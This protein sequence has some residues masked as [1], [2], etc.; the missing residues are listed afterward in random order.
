MGGTPNDSIERRIQTDEVEVVFMTDEKR[1][2]K[3]SKPFTNSES[4]NTE[5]K[6]E[7][8]KEVSKIN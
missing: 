8:R 6:R 3:D 2:P 1:G 7:K 5:R 4:V